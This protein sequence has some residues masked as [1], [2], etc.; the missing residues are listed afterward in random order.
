MK[1]YQE[2]IRP[3]AVQAE[4]GTQLAAL[5]GVLLRI[6]HTIFYS[7]VRNKVSRSENFF[8]LFECVF[9]EPTGHRAKMLTLCLKDKEKTEETE[10]TIR[11]FSPIC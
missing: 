6:V 1:Y 9:K 7:Q 8:D 4:L 2:M 10:R 3:E 5:D 11:L